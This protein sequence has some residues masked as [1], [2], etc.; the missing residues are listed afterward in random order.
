MQRLL[1]LTDQ[2]AQE[3]R[4]GNFAGLSLR[5]WSLAKMF[6]RVAR[7]T[8]ATTVKESLWE[9][10]GVRGMSVQGSVDW[11]S[12]AKGYT[13]MY[14]IQGSLFR[15]VGYR[16]AASGV[17]IPIIVDSYTPLVFEKLS[18]AGSSSNPESRIQ[19]AKMAALGIWQAGDLYVCASRPQ[20]D[21]LLGALST[22]GISDDPRIVC[23][24]TLDAPAPTSKKDWGPRAA[25]FGGVYPWMNIPPVLKAMNLVRKKYRHLEF[26]VIGPTYKKILG[27][28]DDWENAFANYSDDDWIRVVDWVEYSGIGNVLKPYSL[29]INW[30]K[31]FP[32]DRLSFRSRLVTALQRGI[33]VITNGED[34]LSIL[35]ADCGAGVRV[36]KESD[37]PEAIEGLLGD[38]KRLREM[39][40]RTRL[41]IDRLQRQNEDSEADLL[42]FI[43]SPERRR[44]SRLRRS[45]VLTREIKRF[46]Y[47]LKG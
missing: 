33:P 35:A 3:I 13:V 17:D 42:R 40:G 23:W 18:Y 12:L 14:L 43:V 25:W 31:G 36:K 45:T 7:V 1:L 29:I 8:I 24:R 11:K 6:S 10:D 32:E 20:A 2:S 22:A 26:A 5:I 30:A 15:S 27:F 38:R 41:V 37:L 19:E 34:E 21:Y 28:E 44:R 47:W 9:K 39:S 4:S 46:A 16:F